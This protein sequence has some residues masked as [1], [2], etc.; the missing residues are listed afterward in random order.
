MSV[1][2]DPYIIIKIDGN[3][4][5]NIGAISIANALRTNNSLKLLD[6]SGIIVFK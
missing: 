5:G 2:R 6:L 1:K 4:I 3:E